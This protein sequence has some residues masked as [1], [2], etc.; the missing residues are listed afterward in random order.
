MHYAFSKVKT[1]LMDLFPLCTV[2]WVRRQ[3]L[4]VPF[5]EHCNKIRGKWIHVQNHS[6]SNLNKTYSSFA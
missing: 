3:L 5:I 6:K 1:F 4:L 2:H